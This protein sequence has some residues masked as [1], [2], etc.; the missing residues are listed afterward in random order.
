MDR[1]DPAKWIGHLDETAEIE[2]DF[3]HVIVSPYEISMNTVA[4]GTKGRRPKPFIVGSEP[5]VRF[6]RILGF[7]SVG[8]CQDLIASS[9]YCPIFKQTAVTYN[10]PQNNSPFDTLNDAK[11]RKR[12]AAQCPD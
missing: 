4:L 11:A 7:S 8:Q 2:V 12:Q 1:A 3:K 5:N 10:G 9:V 6:I